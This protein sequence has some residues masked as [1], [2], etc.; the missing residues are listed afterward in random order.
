MKDWYRK[1]LT[2]IACAIADKTA[3]APNNVPASLLRPLACRHTAPSECIEG[4]PPDVNEFR[5]DITLNNAGDAFP[6][7][8][9]R[10]SAAPSTASEH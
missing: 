2:D 3:I 6:D 8:A 1:R 7:S 9:T 4:F 10:A 5:H